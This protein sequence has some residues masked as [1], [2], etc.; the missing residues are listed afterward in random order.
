M[1]LNVT[2]TLTL[3]RL[4]VSQRI[5]DLGA[6]TEVC[7]TGVDLYN[8]LHVEKVVKVVDLYV[9]RPIARNSPLKR[10]VM[11]H[12]VFTLQTHHTCLHLV[13]VHQT[14]PPLTVIAVI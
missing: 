11:D 14:A 6:S 1:S 2:L 8:R 4:K 7:V 3:S 9:L 13:N 5:R 12:T 10:S